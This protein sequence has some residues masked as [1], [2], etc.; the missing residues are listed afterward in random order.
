M[1]RIDVKEIERMQNIMSRISIAP[2]LDITGRHFRYFCRLLTKKSMLYTE[3]ITSNAIIYGD[4]KKLLD[5]DPGRK[6]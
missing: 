5:F 2:M 3:T 4:R 1:H 6:A